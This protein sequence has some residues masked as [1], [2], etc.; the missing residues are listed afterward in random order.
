V[1]ARLSVRLSIA[2]LIL[3][4][5]GTLAGSPAAGATRRGDRDVAARATTETSATELLAQARSL[6]VGFS[7]GSQR[8][9]PGATSDGRDVT[10]LLTELARNVDNLPTADQ[11]REARAILARPTQGGTPG[12]DIEHSYTTAEQEP[13][14]DE[15]CIHYVASTADQASGS[16]VSTVQATMATVWDKEIVSLGYRAPRSDLAVSDHGP[17]GRLDVYLQDLP[18]G[19]Y[20]Y[21]VPDT[22]NR[23]TSG[24]CVLDN[25]YSTREFPDNTPTENLRVTAA[26]EFFHAVQFAYDSWENAWLMEGTAAWMEDEVY[27]GINDN[28][29][30]LA[31]SQQHYPY[32]PLDYSGS[33]YLPYGSWVFWRFL[34]ERTGSGASD[35]P[36]FIRKVWEDAVGTTYSIEALKKALRARGTNFRTIYG[37]FGTWMSHPGH[38]FSEGKRYPTA[39]RDG[40]FTLTRAHPSASKRVPVSHMTHSFMRLTPGP[41]LTGAWRLRVS[42]NMAA[43]Y[44]GSAAQLIVS[45]RNGSVRTWA[46]PLNSRGNG[47]RTFGFRRSRL[48]LVEVDMVNVSSRFHCYQGTNQSCHG[49]SYDD[50]LPASFSAKAIR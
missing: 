35:N 21:C 30:Y 42:V 4:M 41:N 19:Y 46:I 25:D 45:R 13:I 31:Q 48:T 5:G 27:D 1:P 38:Y 33:N 15:V 29:Q 37:I 49:T 17:D 9:A 20:G 11:R 44:R 7:A 26:H 39:F 10:M 18:N 36:G 43:P 23:L 6:F 47:T 14:C 3:A 50:D 28:L 12:T 2:C 24:Y 34:S 8:R 16:Y 22:G 40:R 32:I